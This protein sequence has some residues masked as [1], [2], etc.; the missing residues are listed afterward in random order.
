MLWFKE[1]ES[2]NLHNLF[3]LVVSLLIWT[4]NTVKVRELTLIWPAPI[5]EHVDSLCPL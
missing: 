4:V 1:M 2:D 3:I 5:V